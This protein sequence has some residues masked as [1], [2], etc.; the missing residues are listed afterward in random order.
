M[1][2]TWTDPCVP[3]SVFPTDTRPQ[4]PGVGR[5]PRVRGPRVDESTT[6]PMYE[7]VEQSNKDLRGTEGVSGTPLV[8]RGNPLPL[9]SSDTTGVDRR[10]LVSWVGGQS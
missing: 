4:F 3:R 7:G 8:E 9:L 5:G 10:L 1:D 2:R 6:Q